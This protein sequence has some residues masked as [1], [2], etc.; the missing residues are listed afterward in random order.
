[1]WTIIVERDRPQM[2]TWRMR[3]VCW[4]PKATNT[5]TPMLFFHCNNGCTNAPHCYVICTLPVLLHFRI[6]SESFFFTFLSPEIASSINVH[7][8]FHY[9]ALRCPVCS[10]KWFC[11]LVLVDSIICLTHRPDLLFIP[12]NAR[13]THQD[14]TT[15]T[16]SY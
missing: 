8:P 14:I 11:L 6:F 4:T 9:H 12:T 16:C 1:M 7:V 3:I 2:S 5:H 10:Q 15:M 13:Y